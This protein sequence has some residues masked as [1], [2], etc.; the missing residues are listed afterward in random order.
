[1][2]LRCSLGRTVGNKTAMYRAALF[3][4]YHAPVMLTLMLAVL[5]RHIYL[6]HNKSTKAA[7]KYVENVTASIVAVVFFVLPTVLAALCAAFALST[8][9]RFATALGALLG[10]GIISMAVSSF[11]AMRCNYVASPLALRFKVLMSA[12]SVLLLAWA[13]FTIARAN[14]PLGNVA[15]TSQVLYYF[16]AYVPLILACLVMTL[17][18][19]NR[20]I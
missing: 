10:F 3:T 20:P 7:S 1:M 16:F 9:L 4:G 18:E 11:V 6:N 17:V 13:A 12:V 8:S 2:A 5:W 15:R 14:V 19:T